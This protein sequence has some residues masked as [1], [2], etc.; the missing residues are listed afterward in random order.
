[1]T[2]SYFVSKNFFT[3]IKA[4][5]KQYWSNLTQHDYSMYTK[6]HFNDG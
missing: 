6:C 5:T 4:I 3:K 1:M 2:I